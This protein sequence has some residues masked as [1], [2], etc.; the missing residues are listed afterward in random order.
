MKI[1]LTLILL[2]SILLGGDS[3]S[4]EKSNWDVSGEFK[5]RAFNI[6]KNILNRPNYDD[7]GIY[8]SLQSNIRYNK[9]N[10]SFMVTPYA[11]ISKTKSNEPCKNMNFSKPFESNDFFF[12]ALYISYKI[13]N[14]SYGIGIIP[15][16][17]GFPMQYSSD[18]YSDGEGLSILSDGNPLSLFV[19][20]K[21]ND[22]NN[23]ISS[24]GTQDSGV[25]PNGHYITEDMKEDTKNLM[26]IH[27]YDN[28]KFHMKNEILHLHAYYKGTHMVTNTLLGTGMSYDDSEYSGWTVYNSIGLSYTDSHSSNIKNQLLKDKGISQ[29][30]YNNNL[31]S[32]DFSDSTHTGASSLLGARKDFET[33]GNDSFL[34]FEW[35]HTFGDWVSGN[36]GAP[37]TGNCNY[38]SNIR[39]NSYFVN[40][41]YR[42]GKDMFMQVNYTYLEFDKMTV[43]GSPASIT[44]S[45]FM[46]PQ[47]DSTEITKISFSYKF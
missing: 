26:I 5:T 42:L 37:Y 38:I 3:L 41:G 19:K 12:R 23:I 22:N 36:R 34:N 33:F 17:N 10:F 4:N 18:Y 16:G 45:E 2:C 27:N 21:I 47:R 11:H 14:T 35:F 30:A 40:Y 6:K 39:D 44:T 1:V 15:A 24:I 28:D 29:Q 43:I 13:D 31:E 46:G 9:D 25:I 20:H 8:S 32:F 7:D